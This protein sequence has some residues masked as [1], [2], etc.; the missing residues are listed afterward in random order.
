MKI[1]RVTYAIHKYELH[2]LCILFLFVTFMIILLFCDFNFVSL[3][4]VK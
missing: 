4:F 2:C 1:S 3:F